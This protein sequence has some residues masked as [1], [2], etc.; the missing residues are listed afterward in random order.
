M[1]RLQRLEDE[2]LQEIQAI[3]RTAPELGDQLDGYISENLRARLNNNEA[4]Y[5]C[6]S[7]PPT[8]PLGNSSDLNLE[9]YDMSKIIP[10]AHGKKEARKP[11]YGYR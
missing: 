4:Q 5:S 7:S 1:I 10:F 8:A 3:L 2:T 9:D 6:M 11:S